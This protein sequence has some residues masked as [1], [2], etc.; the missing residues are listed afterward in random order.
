MKDN[1]TST[2]SH[3]TIKIKASARNLIAKAAEKYKKPMGEFVYQCVFFIHKHRYDP[4]QMEDIKIAEEFKKFSDRMISFIRN[5][6]Q[7]YISPMYTL[8]QDMA[9]QFVVYQRVMEE[10]M[11]S[12]AILAPVSDD[13]VEESINPSEDKVKSLEKD[14]RGKT[15]LLEQ[16]QQSL[17]RLRGVSVV[18]KREI[19]LKISAEEFDELTSINWRSEGDDTLPSQNRPDD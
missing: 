16:V 1:Q 12:Q 19:H 17:Q 11:A 14:L 7:K 15:E 5:Q 10:I 9:K 18:K 2:P 4:Y 13:L 3:T 6:E 8:V